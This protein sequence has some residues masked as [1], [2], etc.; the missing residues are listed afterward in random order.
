[1][2][3]TKY[4]AAKYIRLS[5]ADDKRNRDDSKSEK[6]DKPSESIENQR[7]LIDH[8]IE[9]QPDIEAVS[10][11]IDDG[12]TGIIFERKAFKE[13]M[14][15]VEAGLINCIIVKDL[16]RFGREYIE[17]G[18]YL[19]NILPAYGVRF[20][21]INDNIDT[22]KESA[23]GLV[24]GVKTIVND[25]YSRD[26]S[27]K[28]R[29]ILDGKRKA[30]DYVGSCPI[31]GYMRDEDN[32]NRLAIDEH[33][34][35]VVRDIYRMKIDGMSALKIAET[36][37]ATGVLSPLE[38]KRD[39][40]LPHPR[41]GF[42]D[43][44][45]AKWSATSVIRILKD[46]TYTGTLVQGRQGTP[47]YKIK[48][49]VDRPQS[50]WKRVEDAHDAIIRRAEYDL[51]RRLLRIDTRTAPGKSQIH[52][53]SGIL[54]CGCCGARMTRKTVPYKGKSYY[55]Y[56]CPTGKKRG[57]EDGVM[58]KETNLHECI[59]DSIRAHI[60]NIASLEGVLANC[61]A[62]RATRELVRY[63]RDQI[64]ENNRQLERLG[65]FLAPLYESMAQDLIDKKE[66]KTLKGQ[67]LADQARLREANV[68]LEDELE[69]ALAG[70][71]D[72]LHWMEQFRQ[73]EGLAELDRRVVVTLL[74]SIRV[75]GKT[76]LAI[77]FSYNVEYEQA[78]AIARG[79]APAL[80]V[81]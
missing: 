19:R 79:M 35:S 73:F 26:I 57:C 3:E 4:K 54:V 1:M 44:P 80:E 39:R 47:N 52:M 13:M 9:G 32:K 60:A 61:D 8:F 6:Q 23:D 75:I 43:K 45:G 41:G 64:A 11:K 49:I 50:E 37:N 10:E 5:Y 33:P 31:Y 15:D 12:V 63:Y 68:A 58:L 67:F 48:D 76:E 24:V 16:S 71:A 53:F 30:G 78:L 29:S 56:F 65:R 25:A 51:V 22:L 46:E 72:R 20:I 42:T 14:A 21:A 62:Q 7:K 69:E 81:A 55:Y 74:K 38:Y 59:L 66:F 70:K 17:T 2:L 77:T 36:L 27:T 34:A 28:T 18:R 40:G